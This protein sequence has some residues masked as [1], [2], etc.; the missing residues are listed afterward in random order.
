[1]PN[2]TTTLLVRDEERVNEGPTAS[3]LTHALADY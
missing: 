3:L 2:T 1:M